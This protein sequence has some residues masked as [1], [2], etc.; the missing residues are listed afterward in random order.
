MI[1]I[2]L[3]TYNGEK[4]IGELLDS[5]LQQTVKNIRILVRDD[6]STDAT[7][8]VIRKYKQKNDI[9]IELVSNNYGNIGSTKSFEKLIEKSDAEYFMFCDQ[10]DV[11]LPDKIEKTY[12]KMRE[13]E[14]YNL[15]KPL[16]VFTDLIV[17]DSALSKISESF[18]QLQRLKPQVCYN[19][20]QCMALSVA[21]GCTMML[22]SKCKEYILP[23]PR[24]RVHD[25]WVITNIA[26][27]GKC[28]FV[29]E[30][31]ILYRQHQN[32][33]IG[34]QSIGI[35]S[36]LVKL[37]LFYKLVP[38]YVREFSHYTFKVKYSS[39]VFFKFKFFLERFLI[40]S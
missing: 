7:L 12:N 5:L 26:Y 14:K 10:D 19:P 9:E 20:W 1:D 16:L 3:A 13:L 28:D 2:L 31:T 11:W 24:G 6:G 37:S 27:W 21:P 38:C 17:V 25:H 40:N 32:N 15:N 8:D 34:L 35:K 36:A 30:G 33:S 22:N 18:F 39:V 29:S 4:Y 23:I